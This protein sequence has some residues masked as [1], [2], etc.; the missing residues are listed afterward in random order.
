MA[1]RD[2]I[3][4]SRQEN[5]LPVP[6]SAA[7]DRDTDSHPLLSLHREVNRL[8][9]DA[10]RGFGA[11]TL[12][13]F[14]RAAGWPHVELGETDKELRVT[15]ELPGLDEKDVEISVEEGALTLRGEKRSEVEDKD[16]GYSERSYG[17][18]ER[19]IGLPKGVDRDQA[20]ASFRNGVLT[21]TLPKTE[22][23]NEDV[24]RIPINGKAA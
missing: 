13:G 24:R 18:F 17:R 23:A 8:F 19:R 10:F 20:S 21:V 15:A 14:D 3:P 5:R 6:V 22:A 4:W 1:F 11:P 12:A 9:D 7:R 16:R 2:L